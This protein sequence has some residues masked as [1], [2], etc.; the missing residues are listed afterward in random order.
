VGRRRGAKERSVPPNHGTL[1]VTAPNSTLIVTPSQRFH[2]FL[3]LKKIIA[4]INIE[5]KTYKNATNKSKYNQNSKRCHFYQKLEFF[6]YED[7]VELDKCGWNAIS[8]F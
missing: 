1:G 3:L 7:Q 4:L 2:D 5:I 8:T 6:K